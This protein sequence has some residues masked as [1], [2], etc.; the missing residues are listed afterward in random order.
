MQADPIAQATITTKDAR[1]IAAAMGGVIERRNTIP[2]LGCLRFKIAKGGISVTGTD[3]DIRMTLHI[4]AETSGEAVILIDAARFA[5][6]AGAGLGDIV[7]KVI[8]PAKGSQSQMN[9]IELSSGDIT[10]QLLDRLPPEDFPTFNQHLKG[11]KAFPAT[12]SDLLRVFKLASHCISTEETRYY[13][14]GIYL[15]EKPDGTTLRGV[16][17]D[18]HRLACIDTGVETQ[19]GM[20]K[21]EGKGAILP[22]KTVDLLKS[23]M[24][25]GA[26]DPVN[27]RLTNTHCAFVWEGVEIDTK[28][29]DGT[30]PDYTRVIPK[31]DETGRV[32]LS[33]DTVRRVMSIGRA[34]GGGTSV[35]CALDLDA[36]TM[37]I[38][39]ME[40]EKVAAPMSATGKGRIG[41]NLKYLAQLARAV[42]NITMQVI[43][44]NGPA[45]CFGDDPLAMFVLM[46][47]R[48]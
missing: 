22:R 13:L 25:E 43:E 5:G 21:T 28:M 33:T 16:A 37:T 19:G 8:P 47:M 6:F 26:N 2:V 29:I 41:F 30:Y 15:S 44:A 7:L 45:R 35:A 34:L 20:D 46:P 39:G 11:A 10:L 32:Q 23:L 1:R 42:P 3:L 17:T 18:G 14:N 9:V 24:T 38:T 48:V 31:G 27:M 12:Q 40:G 36:N 4:E